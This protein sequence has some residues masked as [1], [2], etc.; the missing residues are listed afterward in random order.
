VIRR[1]PCQPIQLFIRECQHA[2][3]Y[4]VNKGH[5]VEIASCVVRGPSAV[6]CGDVWRSAN[7]HSRYPSSLRRFSSSL[8][9]DSE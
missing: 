8:R 7:D 5:G 4:E 6:P 3:S 1:P 2:T 9:S